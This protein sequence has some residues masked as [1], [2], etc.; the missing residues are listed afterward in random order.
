MGARGMVQLYCNAP[1][2]QNNVATASGYRYSGA[3]FWTAINNGG[4]WQ[5]NDISD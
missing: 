1:V 4:V 2:V 3:G 5:N